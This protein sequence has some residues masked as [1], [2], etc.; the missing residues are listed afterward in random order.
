M[1]SEH[2][3]SAWLPRPP[4]SIEY[5]GRWFYSGGYVLAAVL[6]AL[7]FSTPE[8][9]GEPLSP[10][11]LGAPPQANKHMSV[12][13]LTPQQQQRWSDST[14]LSHVQRAASPVPLE[15]G[16]TFVG[17][18]RLTGAPEFAAEVMGDQTMAAAAAVPESGAQAEKKDDAKANSPVEMDARESAHR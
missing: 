4:R 18:N 13:S 1:T 16:G 5:G 14:G 12:A 2:G 15:G 9:P 6:L 3:A 10:E 8:A 7:V 17:Y 11:A